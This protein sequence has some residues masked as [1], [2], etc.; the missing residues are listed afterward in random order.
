M[1]VLIIGGSGTIGWPIVEALRASR[2]EVTA[3]AR[4]PRSGDR[5]RRAGCRVIAGDLRQ[6]HAWLA[7]LGLVE[8][9]IHVAA[10]WG[11]DMA[12]AEQALIDGI[13]AH[14]GRHA[15]RYGR[16][17]RLVYTGG[18]WLYGAVG[19][20]TAVEGCPFDPLPAYS[21]MVDHRARLFEAREIDACIVHPA[22]VWHDDGGAI[23]RF[24]QQARRRA[25]PQ[26]IGSFRT[27]WPLVHASDLAQLYLLAAA[28]GADGADYH[29][30]AE[31]GVPVGEI[32]SAIA[33][34]FDAPAPIEQPVAQ[35]IAELGEGAAGFA[36]DITMDAPFTRENLGW[37]PAKPGILDSLSSRPA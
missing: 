31:T 32:A 23:G 1:N 29:G 4:S 22:L 10:A 7:D 14:A 34:K 37:A 8:A 9:I 24:L 25:A 11:G 36:L 33:V 17:I 26:V 27:R 16:R 13:L 3:L 18:C 2:H 15:A 19:D 20:R 28:R 35:A 30:V 5:L 12:D 6:P 21:Y